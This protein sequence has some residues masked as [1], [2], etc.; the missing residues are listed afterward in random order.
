MTLYDMRFKV[1]NKTWPV[2]IGE[3]RRAM[4]LAIQTRIKRQLGYEV[5]Q[6]AI[7]ERAIQKFH[8]E[9]F[10]DDHPAPQAFVGG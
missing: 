4:L 5:T 1:E 7:V 3:E 2:N 9:L 10:K 8:E 6:R